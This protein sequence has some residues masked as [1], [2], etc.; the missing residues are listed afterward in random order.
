MMCRDLVES[1]ASI[2]L[3]TRSALPTKGYALSRPRLKKKGGITA[4]DKTPAELPAGIPGSRTT[5]RGPRGPVRRRNAPRAQTQRHAQT[6]SPHAKL[7]RAQ[8]GKDQ[9]SRTHQVSAPGA[10]CGSRHGV[11]RVKNEKRLT[12]IP[13]TPFAVTRSHGVG[14]VPGG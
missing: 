3:F 11:L 4:T 9:G 8:V 14:P 2:Y 10:Q 13:P 6:T 5:G 12:P 7:R 1:P